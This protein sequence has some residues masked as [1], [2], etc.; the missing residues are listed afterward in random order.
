[1]DDT[2]PE[3]LQKQLIQVPAPT[4]FTH[5]WALVW[6]DTQHG[7]S[8]QSASS[9]SFQVPSQEICLT[10]EYLAPGSNSEAS[11]LPKF[12]VTD[13]YEGVGSFMEGA[14]F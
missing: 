1:M 2:P 7:S 3:D 11:K 14:D 6:C 10:P 4:V 13:P 12:L 5:M 8:N 9:A